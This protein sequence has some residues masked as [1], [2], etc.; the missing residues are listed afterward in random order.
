MDRIRI[1]REAAVYFII[2]VVL[3]SVLVMQIYGQSQD[4]YYQTALTHHVSAM[5]KFLE[6]WTR[7]DAVVDKAEITL[8]RQATGG[9]IPPFSCEAVFIREHQVVAQVSK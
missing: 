5:D 3:S 2:M 6:G 9:T 8:T 1:M 7:Y 4:A